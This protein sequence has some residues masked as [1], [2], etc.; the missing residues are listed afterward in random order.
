M[1]RMICLLGFLLGAAEGYSQGERQHLGADMPFFEKQAEKYQEWLDKRGMGEALRVERVRFK[2]KQGLTDSTELELFLLLRADNIDTA[3][4]KWWRLKQDFDTDSDSLEACLFRTFIHKM[5]IPEAQGNIQVYI[6]NK[7]GAYIK[8]NHIFI[9]SDNGV[10][11]RQIR[12][13]TTRAKSF[14]I[15]VPYPI[16]AAGKSKSAKVNAAAKRRSPD[17]VF[18]LILYHVRLNMLE[19]PRYRNEL[20]DRRPHIENDSIRTATTFKFAVADMGREVMTNQ[21]RY[22]WEQWFGLNTIAM[23][24]LTFA[25]EYL[26][27]N[28]DGG[29]T[30]KCSIDGKYGSGVFKPRSSAYEDMSPDFDDFFEKYKNDFRLKLQQILAP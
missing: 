5:E 24:R 29:Y 19:H 2:R 9:W 3:F 10:L 15:S 28:A 4:A 20:S 26:P 14:E 11:Q 25:F 16:S 1:Y 21:S 8:N 22:I 12:G 7:E 27:S 13:G 18:N 23:E 6:R 17:A 30:I